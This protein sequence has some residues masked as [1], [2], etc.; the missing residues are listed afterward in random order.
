MTGSDQ[1]KEQEKRQKVK[2]VNCFPLIY[3]NGILG[4]QWLKCLLESFILNKPN[5]KRPNLKGHLFD[6]DILDLVDSGS[7]LSV[8]GFSGLLW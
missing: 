6:Q 5:A 2:V 4:L 3:K 8:L 7:Y 1:F